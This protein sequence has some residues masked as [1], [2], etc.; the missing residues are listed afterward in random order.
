MSAE[1]S[2]RPV[3]VIGDL[4]DRDP[5]TRRKIGVPRRII[6]SVDVV[7]DKDVERDLT[8]GGGTLDAESI[9]RKRHHT[10]NPFLLEES[11]D[12]GFGGERWRV[13]Q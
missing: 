11:V 6:G 4:R 12:V 8:P 9:E 10:P 13:F 7:G 2:T 5:E 1:T 3:Q